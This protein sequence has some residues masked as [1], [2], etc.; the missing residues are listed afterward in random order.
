MRAFLLTTLILALS[1]STQN[2][3]ARRSKSIHRMREFRPKE[4]FGTPPTFLPS[5][6][7]SKPPN[8]ATDVACQVRGGAC[9]D[10]DATVL[11]K[12]GVSAAVETALLVGVFYAG[13]EIAENFAIGKLGGLPISY[14]L[15]ILTVV[16]GSSFFG[17]FVDGGISAASDQA[18][19]PNVVPGDPN[20]YAKLKKPSWN[21]PG[22]VFPI[23][24]LIVSKPTQAIALSKLLQADSIPWD[25]LAVYCAH[26]S[27]GDAWNKVFF[28]FQC[29]GKG[30]AVISVF[31]GLLL[32]SAYLFYGVDPLAGK[33]LLPTC[34]WVTIATA[35]NWNIYLNN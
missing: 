18:L 25:I 21:P 1:V 23:M 33:F 8:T 26:L 15:S 29:T 7:A 5:K 31:F 14:W 20:W 3:D 19:D 4:R 35:L 11:F 17:S 28:G 9:S 32:S 24:W 16:F 2:V 22:W 12:V 6:K 30:A 13:K 27:L 34:G 10:A